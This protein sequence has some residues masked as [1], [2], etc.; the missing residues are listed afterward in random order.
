MKKSNSDI[1]RRELDKLFIDCLEISVPV[2]NSAEKVKAAILYQVFF[3][4]L[5]ESGVLYHRDNLSASNSNFSFN[6]Y[7]ENFKMEASGNIQKLFIPDMYA[8]ISRFIILNL[9]EFPVYLLGSFFYENLLTRTFKINPAGIS[10]DK[11]YI[12]N[13]GVFY[14]PWKTAETFIN[15]LIG[16]LNAGNKDISELKVLDLACGCGIFSILILKVLAEMVTA[17][18][19]KEESIKTANGSDDLSQTA[20][21]N[22]TTITRLGIL[23]N[24]IFA[25][26]NDLTA[27]EISKYTLLLFSLSEEKDIISINQFTNMCITLDKNIQK[28]DVIDFYKNKSCEDLNIPG[29]KFD[30]VVSNPPYI[31]YYSRHSKSNEAFQKDLPAMKN[32]LSL[33][34]GIYNDQKKSGRLNS[35]LFFVDFLMRFLSPDALFGLLVDMSIHENLYIE[36]RKWI[37]ENKILLETRLNINDFPGVNSGQTFLYM[38]NTLPTQ[39]N[40]VKIIDNNGGEMNI[41]EQ[42]ILKQKSL[43]YIKKGRQF[44]DH[45]S[46]LPHLGDHCIISTGVN[47]GGASEKFLSNHDGG[48]SFYPMISTLMLKKPYAV[49]SSGYEHYIDFSKEKAELINQESRN[50]NIK[51]VVALGKLERF[52][53]PKIFVRQSAP[54]I[55]ATYSDKPVISPYSIFVINQKKETGYGLYVLLAILN[56]DLVSFYCVKNRLISQGA[57]KQPQIRKSC[58]QLIPVPRFENYRRFEEE[59]EKRVKLYVYENINTETTDVSHKIAIEK[60]VCSM[61]EVNYETFKAEN[62]PFI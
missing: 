18:I 6:D 41:A 36:L 20:R 57:G 32:K 62:K 37:L 27:L 55:I 25:I 45:L 15:G 35:I 48:G 49:I 28:I 21:K 50:R 1:S 26:D 56:S 24:N 59:L 16:N 47:I 33:S 14:T 7:P 3:Y 19:E 23:K 22:Q 5:L 42:S 17:K 44:L 51:S 60:L 46:H 38:Q 30:L 10:Y 29:I 52:L 2:L 54:R 9:S 13:N 4:S 11:Q 61:Y 58:L 39:E 31:S 43:F 40:T 34:C 12:K 53:K 8:R